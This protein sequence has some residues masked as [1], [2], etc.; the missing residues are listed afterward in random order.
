[1]PGVALGKPVYLLSGTLK[2]NTG[3]PIPLLDIFFTINGTKVGEVR[4]NAAGFFQRKFNNKFSGRHIYHL[5]NYEIQPFLSRAAGSTSVEILPADVR[6]QT[7][8]SHP[9]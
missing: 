9:A 3:V 2:A 5:R 6:V 4:T 8:P 7:V 1:V